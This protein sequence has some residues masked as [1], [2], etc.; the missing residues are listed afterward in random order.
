MTRFRVGQVLRVLAYTDMLM[1]FFDDDRF[2]YNASDNFFFYALMTL[3]F[4][5][6]GID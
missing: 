4:L 5:G 2:A 3:F 1:S 6:K